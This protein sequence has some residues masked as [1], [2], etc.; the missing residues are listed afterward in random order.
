ME[1]TGGKLWNFLFPFSPFIHP[2]P[3]Y[4]LHFPL[5]SP[6]SPHFPPYSP[7]PPIPHHFSWGRVRDRYVGGYGT[8][9][10]VWVFLRPAYPLYSC[11]LT[12]LEI[13]QVHVRNACLS[14]HLLE[15]VGGERG[16][17]S[18]ADPAAATVV[19]FALLHNGP[20]ITPDM[21]HFRPCRKAARTVG[22][23]RPNAKHPLS[24]SCWTCCT[25]ARLWARPKDRCAELVN[26]MG[27]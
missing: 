27:T 10:L 1:G 5:F 9:H 18:W 24:S 3:P 7:F 4:S 15:K 26:P 22:F 2:S 17:L 21:T 12:L 23:V 19:P 6:V 16:W 13:F 20:R 11:L 25:Q 14:A 8:C